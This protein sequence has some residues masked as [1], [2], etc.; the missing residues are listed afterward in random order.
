MSDTIH[1]SGP[2]NAAGLEM[3]FETGRL[4]QLA[5]DLL[6]LASADA[7]A[8][9]IRRSRVEVSDMLDA[10][11][12][13]YRRRADEA[14]RRI[15]IDVSESPGPTILADQRRLEQA[16]SNLVENALGH[17]A[18]TIRLGAS[19]LNGY[20]ELRV[21]DEGQGFPPDFLADAFE[22]FSRPDHSRGRGGA[23]LGLGIV[24]A[25]AEAHGGTATAGSGA[26]GGAEVTI[27]LP[28]QRPRE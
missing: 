4:A 22:R 7:G 26:N 1:V 3:S 23:G 13:R 2:V 18:G 15:E 12:A 19:Q 6:L 17:G 14:E 25:T 10:V 5:D 9:A 11:A 16:L 20:L 24:A 8:L 27:S 21:T 28:Q